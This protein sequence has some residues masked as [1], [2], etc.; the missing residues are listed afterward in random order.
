[1]ELILPCIELCVYIKYVSTV[2]QV[3]ASMVS[4]KLF[5]LNQTLFIDIMIS[6]VLH[7]FLK[8]L[9]CPMVYFLSLV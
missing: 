1:M 2:S 7:N 8:R 3:T 5:G 6:H 9:S 4:R